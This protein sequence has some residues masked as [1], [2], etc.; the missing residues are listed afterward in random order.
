MTSLTRLALVSASALALTAC[1]SVREKMPTFGGDKAPASAPA[2]QP[3]AA[4][5]KPGQWSQ[6]Q[7]DLK[8][9]DN[10]RFGALPNGMRYAIM[11]NATPPG[12]AAL[13]LRFD[14]GSLMEND[15]QQGLAHFLEHMA[16]NGS[17][18]IPEGEMVKTLERLGLAFGADTNAS[19]NFDETV[20]KLDLPKTDAETVDTSLKIM[21]ETASELL[22]EQTSV[23]RERGVVLS[24][25]RTRDGPAY[26][27]YKQR[28]DF[29]MKGQRPPSRYPIGLVDVLKTAPR[30]KINDFYRAYY[31]PERATIVAVG[32]F[33]V[34][35][36]EAKIKAVFSDWKNDTPDGANPDMGPVA[37]RGQEVKVV[38]EPGAA[39]GLTLSWVSSP[40]LSTDNAAR[41]RRD[42]IEQLGF[43]VLNRRL[44]RLT[45]AGD[46]PFI[47]AGGFSGDQLRAIRMTTLQLTTQPGEWKQGLEAV[48]LEQR[49]LVQFGVRQDELDR[50]IT[51][52]RTALQNRVDG[53]ATRRTTAL[54][55]EIADSVNDREVV[56]SPA[57]DLALF[58]ATVKDLKADRVSGVMKSAFGGGGPLV[59]LS[60]S[61][62]VPGGEQAVSDALTASRKVAVTASAV[63]AQTAWPY[64]SFG[65]PGKVAEQ[66]DITDLDA[67]FVRFDNGVRLT[68]KPTKFRTDQILV[69]V[70]M[71]DG[72]LSLPKDKQP[73]T[74]AVSSFTE[75]GLGKISTQDMEQVLASKT[76][77][78]NLTV[79]E[80]SLILSGG[81][82][83]ADLTTQLQ[84]LAAYS[85]DAGWRPESF[86]RIKGFAATL[87]DQ[88]EATDSGVLSR[89]LAGLLHPG[90]R[91]FTFPKPAEIAATT[92]NDL[93][94]DVQAQ[95]ANGPI[96]VTI[97]GDITVEKA[98]QAVA[99]TF[100][101]LPAR[102]A[103]WTRRADARETGFPAPS[104]K[105]VVL[106]HKGRPDQAIAYITWP[107]TD[108]Y[109][110]PQKARNISILSDVMGNRL[111]EVLREQ[112]GATYSPSV[113]ATSS[114]VWTGWGQISAR[115]EVPPA[116]L[117]GFFRDVLK[118]AADLRDHPPTDDE[119][120]RAK[121]PRLEQIEKAKATNEFWISR[122]SG[123]QTDPRK[124]D[125]VRTL[126]AGVERVS[127]ADVQAAAREFL[128][129]DKSWRLVV[130]A[131]GQ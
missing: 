47:S 77:G 53:A 43:A 35:A 18:A 41:R 123:A 92:Q 23:D 49:R 85:T 4:D 87:N 91:R 27:I 63:A 101:A 110:N 34:D 119:M 97:V 56:T 7:S 17:K 21:R 107:T 3:P 26:R 25:E 93:K 84:I 71:G 38:V 70:R 68:V 29:L 32:D 67:V 52:Y 11:K 73:A 96:E 1:A 72:M 45:R 95:L 55:E 5:L 129:E 44:E 74:W 37:K 89:D 62:A 24:E 83:Q 122:L 50:E 131:A 54:A 12:Q 19:T 108:F 105:P 2:Q 128:K 130:K 13:R 61:V 66:K 121:K 125:D 9:D 79:G 16:F 8:A 36:M 100:G 88:Y 115:V 15:D 6:A 57:E 98:T 111:L 58:E 59:F 65:A 31:R 80:D 46:P 104:T 103:D 33:D 82:K 60:T 99:E 117:D 42:W 14:A 114:Q 76:Y 10:V 90:D 127:A 116:L 126:T 112:Q 81:T 51:E 20:Y 28:N 64:D 48:D 124:L 118:I 30:D 40:D 120:A 86:Q 69:Q 102:E 106:T 39:T 94:T 22:I 109:S 78:A 113:S 75:G